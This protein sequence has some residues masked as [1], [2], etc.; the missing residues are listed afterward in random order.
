MS[1]EERSASLIIITIIIK[2]RAMFNTDDS[3]KLRLQQNVHWT[4]VIIPSHF[5]RVIRPIDV[6]LKIENQM[7]Q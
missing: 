4:S 6:I 3:R 1:R 7:S 5:I 2:Q